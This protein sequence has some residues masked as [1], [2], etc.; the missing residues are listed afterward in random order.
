MA[1]VAGEISGDLL[2]SDVLSPNLWLFRAVLVKDLVS[3]ELH[4]REI[5]Y[6]HTAYISYKSGLHEPQCIVLSSASGLFGYFG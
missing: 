5:E 6:K 2:F 3:I 1:R 4:I